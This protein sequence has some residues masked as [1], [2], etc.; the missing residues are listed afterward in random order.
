MPK[1]RYGAISGLEQEL[2]KEQV[3]AIEENGWSCARLTFLPFKWAIF[4][5]SAIAIALAAAFLPL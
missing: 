4:L 5:A 2:E 1:P 3:Q